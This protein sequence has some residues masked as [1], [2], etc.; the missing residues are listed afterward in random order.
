[1][2]MRQQGFSLKELVIAMLIVAIL[3]TIAMR[4]FGKSRLKTNRENGTE[5]LVEAQKKIENYYNRYFAYP[6]LS[7]IGYTSLQCPVQ[8]GSTQ[9]YKLA[10][11][12]S[13]PISGCALCYQLTATPVGAQAKDENNLLL[14]IDPRDP[15]TSGFTVAYHKQH[16]NLAG[17]TAEGW[18]F[19]PGQ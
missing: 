6:T 8:E 13:S 17:S 19:Q 10:L 18:I 5:C 4:N 11:S 9:L 7:Q 12:S 2:P 14:T 1:M 15:S 3:S 16:T